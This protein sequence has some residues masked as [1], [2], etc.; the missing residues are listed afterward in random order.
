MAKW[1]QQASQWHEMYCHDLKFMSLNPIRIELGVRSTSVLS[2]TWTKN[3]II[4]ERCFVYMYISLIIIWLMNHTRWQTF[5]MSVIAF[6]T[7]RCLAHNQ[8]DYGWASRE[9]TLTMN[10][11]NVWKEVW[12]E[13]WKRQSWPLLSGHLSNAHV[14]LDIGQ[15]TLCKKAT[16][17]Q[18][19]T[20]PA[21][22][23]SVL[24]PGHNHLLTIGTDDITLWL[25]PWSHVAW[26]LPGR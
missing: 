6:L 14:I 20:M 21:T 19:T 23:K 10:K 12:K 8:T 11:I 7:A 16:I 25:S 5:K 1:L 17:Y 24:F 22:S 18:V 3:K 13:N 26:W 4:C 9:I 15:G 2:R